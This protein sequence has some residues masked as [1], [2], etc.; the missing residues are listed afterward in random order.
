MMSFR[1][2]TNDGEEL[3]VDVMP[4]AISAWEIDTRQKASGLARDGFGISDCIQLTYRQLFPPSKAGAPSMDEWAATL[5]EIMPV[6][7]DPT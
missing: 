1:V 4:A 7:G 6:F 5:T 3:T 2:K